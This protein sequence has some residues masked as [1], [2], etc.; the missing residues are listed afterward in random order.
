M[1]VA[2]PNRDKRLNLRATARQESLIRAGAKIRG[3]N[4]TDFILDSACTR[5]EEIIADQT[6]FT[7]PPQQWKKF[8][9][10]LDRP[11]RP[12]PRLKK[13]F[14]EKTVLER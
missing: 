11:S 7:V 12:M 1:P 14:K 5:A 10:A 9:A 2:Q 8:I 4:V 3:V 13:L 6:L